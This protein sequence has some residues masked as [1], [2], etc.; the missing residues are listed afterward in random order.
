MDKAGNIGAEFERMTVQGRLIPDVW[1]KRAT[2]A[3]VGPQAML[4]ATESALK[5]LEK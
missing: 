3:P 5:R 2:G 4:A 1:M